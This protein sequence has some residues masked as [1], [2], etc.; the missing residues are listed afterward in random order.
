MSH[1]A[2]TWA[3]EVRVG[4]PTLKSLLIAICHRVNHEDFLRSGA[5]ECYPSLD[6]LAYD[7]EV[8]KRTI[9]RRLDELE[10]LGF[11]T[12]LQRR[13]LDGTRDTSLIT[14]SSGQIVTLSPVA[15]KAATSGQKPGVPVDTAVHLNKQEEQEEQEEQESCAVAKPKKA[16]GEVPYSDDFEALWQQYPRTKNTSKK[17]AWNIYR[18]LNAERQEQ[19]RRAVPIYAAAMRAEGRPDDKIKHMTSWLNGRM[20]ETAAAPP[21]APRAAGSAPEAPWHTR[22]TR[23]QWVKVLEMY[24]V[25]NSWRPAWGPEPGFPGCAVP[26]DLIDTLPYQLHPKSDRL[27]SG[28][29]N[30]MLQGNGLQKPDVTSPPRAG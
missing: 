30:K 13:K 29:S 10:A 20:Y 1:Q 6:A 28:S 5:W 16:K 23:E 12:I 11:I 17:D 3:M 15:K 8:S 19:V 9:Q 14:V 7:T 24:K 22:A 26:P 4:D 18:M 21:N 2:V 27:L 25:S